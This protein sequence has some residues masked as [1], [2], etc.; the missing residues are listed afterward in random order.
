MG[1]NVRQG[2]APL[3]LP[4]SSPPPQTR[5]FVGI[6]SQRG[7]QAAYVLQDSARVR[8]GSFLSPGKGGGTLPR[9]YV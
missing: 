4:P 9:Y 8:S 6:C 2:L 1:K 7:R 3:P 5:Y